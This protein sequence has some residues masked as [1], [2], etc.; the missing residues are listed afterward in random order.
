M[1]PTV[2]LAPLNSPEIRAN[3]YPFYAHLHTL[4]QA[5][6]VEKG[7]STYAAVV[8]GYDTASQVL[9]DA[10][11]RV[12]DDTKMGGP[13]KW[14]D[15]PTQ[16]IFL[17]S[18]M[19]NNDPRHARMRGMFNRVFTA[20][21]VAGLDGA[22]VTIVDALLDRMASRTADGSPI[23]YMAAYAYP[24]PSNVMGEL[25]GVPE[26]DRDWYRPRAA[27]LGVVLEIGGRTPENV[28]RADAASRE[29]AAYFTDLMAKRRVDPHDDLLTALVQATDENH[30]ILS[31]EELLA[32]LVVLF[33]AG[34]VT[35]T[36]LIGNG[37]TL[38][39]DRPDALE[40]LR[41][42]PD[43][44]PAFVEEMLRVEIPTH[45]VIRW[46][47]EDMEIEG[48]PVKKDDRVL[49]L[50]SA[51]NRDPRRYPDPDTFDP[52][53]ADNQGL[54]FGAGAHFCLGAALAR[55]EGQR[56]FT[57]LLERFEEI[58]LDRTPPPPRQLML[59]GHEE[60]W[61]TLR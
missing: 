57:K 14:E 3:P 7:T 25:L 59:R 49:I 52:L 56:A 4:G 30:E 13:P 31:K 23:D 9:R 5:A 37:L 15:E 38:L 21:R 44:A 26:E 6:A 28:A 54:S 10:R 19:F 41:T 22:V 17:N 36:N 29:L 12:V 16:A 60:L 27:A 39:L 53:R 47:T 50:L 18:V 42:R 51:V 46:A 35:T 40:L 33:N 20:R 8:H 1:Y 58:K 32:N 45:F 34:F 43:L 24:V 55:L 61:V 2:S 11:L 48:V